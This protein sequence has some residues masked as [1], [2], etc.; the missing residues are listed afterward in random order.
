[1]LCLHKPEN[2]N[3]VDKEMASNKIGQK[4]KGKSKRRGASQWAVAWRRFKRNKAGIFG[5]VIVM[6]VFF[7]GIFGSFFAPYPARPDPHAYDPFYDIDPITGIGDVRKPPSWM[8]PEEPNSWKYLFGTTPIGTDVFSDIIHGTKYTVYVGV[9]VT[10]ITM[11]L[12]IAVG[13]IAG[14]YGRWVDNIL[15]RISEVFLV[16]PSLLLILVFVRIFTVSVGEPFLNIPIINIQI[17]T[18]LTIVIVILGLFNWASNARMIRGEFLRV[19]ELEFIEAERALGAGNIRIIFRHILPN[20][21]SSIIVV[22]S[23]T[24][25]YAILLEAAVSFLGFGDANTITWGQILQENFSEMR[26][27]WWAEVFP[28]IAILLTVFGF[29]LLGDGLSDAMNPRLRD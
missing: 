3:Q 12:S 21:M 18:G 10:V 15:M 17:P 23:L 4:K 7:V 8:D 5:L 20:L 26:I 2:K 16:F 14:F 24:I 9:L 25:A 19:R 27:V 11:A 22:S 6:A 29:N 1:M 28:G 13:A